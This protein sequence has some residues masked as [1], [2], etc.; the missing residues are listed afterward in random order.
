MGIFPE[1]HRSYEHKL[2][3]GKTGVAKLALASHVPVIPVG[4]R[5]SSK[6][7]PRD[8]YFLKFK[9][10]EVNIG[11]PLYFEK[12]YKQQN[13]K[14]ALKIVTHKIMKEISKL[15]NYSYPYKE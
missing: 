8:S 14:K 2:R 10:C 5:G 13:N 3:E 1:G 12:Y 15:S 11:K 6:I 4:I 9:R 7:L